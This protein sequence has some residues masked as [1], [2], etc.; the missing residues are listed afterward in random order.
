MRTK[1]GQIAMK[2]VILAVQVPVTSVIAPAAV[3][4][5]W[6]QG[7]ATVA[8]MEV[9]TL[10]RV[11]HLVMQVVRQIF[12][13]PCLV[14]VVGA[15]TNK[16]LKKEIAEGKFR[17]DLYHRL[18]VILIK[19]PALNDRRDD[20]PLLVAHFA[21]K[22]A[23]EQG[24]AKKTF[25]AAAI[26]LLKSYDWTGNIRELRNVVERLIILGGKEVS[27]DDVKLSLSSLEVIWLRRP[28]WLETFTILGSVPFR[29]SGRSCSVRATVSR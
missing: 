9:V 27:E 22:I 5:T 19:V 13:P 21:E 28:N 3:A 18:A 17:E 20:I 14:V 8:A 25:S 12:Q 4:Q 15:A 6:L 7:A 16:D 1:E 2:A 24:T 11:I 26:E 23:N 29:I 10:A